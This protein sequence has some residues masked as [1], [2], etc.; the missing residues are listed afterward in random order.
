MHTPIQSDD[1]DVFGEAA[2][3]PTFFIFI[4]MFVSCGQIDK[5]RSK[6][7]K[8]LLQS[9]KKEPNEMHLQ[10]SFALTLASTHLQTV[11][12]CGSLLK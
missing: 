6:Q 4:I 3:C 8:L 12:I 7:L 2:K 9:P 1:G 11:V 5:L 10:A